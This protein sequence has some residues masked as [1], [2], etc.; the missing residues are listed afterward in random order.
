MN[1]KFDVFDIFYFLGAG[2][3]SAGTWWIYNPAGLITGGIFF[4]VIFFS[5]R[6]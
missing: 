2:L 5:G 4:L 3:V 6:S 1:N